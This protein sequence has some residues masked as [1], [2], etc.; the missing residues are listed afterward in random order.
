MY[1][2]LVT[3]DVSKL[4]G[5]LKTIAPCRVAKGA[6]REAGGGE[7]GARG[8]YT[9][10]ARV[11]RTANMP[12]MSVTPEMFQLDMSALKFCKLE[13]SPLIS[14]MAETSQSARGP[15]V[16]MA[17]A[18]LALN[19]LTAT[20]REAVLVKVPD[21]GDGGDGGDVITD[22]SPAPR[23][24]AQHASPACKP[25]TPQSAKVPKFHPIPYV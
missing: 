6:G 3:L 11:E 22:H 18:G 19:A 21:G 8:R 1:S 4:S 9:D 20:I 24:Q 16:A 17:D 25:S 15:Y 7:V 23:P 2:M 12:V 5:W 10:R 13:K 14:V